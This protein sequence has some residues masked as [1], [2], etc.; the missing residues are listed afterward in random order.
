MESL[1]VSNKPY[2]VLGLDISTS[3]IGI[4]IINATDKKNPEIIEMTHV[5]PKLKKGITGIEALIL[6]K[7]IFEEEFISKISNHLGRYKEYGI[8]HCVIEAPLSFTT[9]GSNNK[10]VATLLQFNALLS[11]CVYDVLGLVPEYISSYDARMYSFPQLLSIRRVNKKGEKYP[12]SKLKKAIKEDALTLFGD[13]PHDCD[14]KMIMMSLVSEKYPDIKW[15]YD[16]DGQ[17]KKENYDACDSLIC[18]LAS[19]NKSMYGEI[20][21]HITDFTIDEEKNVM[22]ITV[23]TWGEDDTRIYNL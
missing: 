18:C 12:V 15:M 6:R 19:L 7:R 23:N 17:L 16:K 5:S 20:D 9:G 3:C 4:S 11:E 14:K 22:E 13:F 1:E 2:I 8:S 10:V 21:S